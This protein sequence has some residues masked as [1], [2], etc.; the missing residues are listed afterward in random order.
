VKGRDLE[1][2]RQKRLSL[3]RRVVI[4]VGT[5]VV[6]GGGGICAE[7]IE[8]ERQPIRLSLVVEEWKCLMWQQDFRQTSPHA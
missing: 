2:E 8:F 6:T 1:S 4:K 5:S 3:A 7:G